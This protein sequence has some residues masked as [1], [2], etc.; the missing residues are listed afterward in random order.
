VKAVPV[1]ADAKRQVFVLAKIVTAP[2][3]AAK[4]RKN[5]LKA[6]ENGLFKIYSTK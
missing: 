5:S 2:A 4:K 6:R 1:I 3:S